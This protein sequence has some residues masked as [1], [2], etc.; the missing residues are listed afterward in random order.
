MRDAILAKVKSL[1]ARCTILYKRH[2]TPQ[3]I[4]TIAYDIGAG[5]S[6]TMTRDE[7][8]E[9]TNYND[10]RNFVFSDSRVIEYENE[11][12]ALAAKDTQKA[13]VRKSVS[14]DADSDVEMVT[15]NPKTVEIGNSKVIE[16]AE[17]KTQMDTD[18]KK[19]GENE[20]NT[21]DSDGDEKATEKDLKKEAEEDLTISSSSDASQSDSTKTSKKTKPAATTALKKRNESSSSSSSSESEEVV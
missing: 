5:N 3:Q 14:A 7:S 16:H 12:K 19:D 9:I 15:D 17:G 13:T 8:R 10:F 20:E 1:G 2:L 6:Q 4:Y 21:E 11:E 18:E